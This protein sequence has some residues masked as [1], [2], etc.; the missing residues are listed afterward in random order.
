MKKIMS[1][2]FVTGFIATAITLTGAP[3]ANAWGTSGH[4]IAAGLAESRLTPTAK[5]EVDRLLAGESKPTLSGVSTWADQIRSDGSALGKESGAWHYVNI[6]ENNCS[7]DPAVNGNNGSNIV[8]AL[9]NQT[10]ILADRTQSDASR[11]QALKFVVHLA[12]DIAQPMHG[13]YAQDR[14]GNSTNVT[15][16]G[17]KTNLHSVWDSRLLAAGKKSD[18][19]YVKELTAQPTPAL[20]STDPAAWVK[21]SCN[22]AVS[23][24]VYPANSTIGNE[25][26]AKYLP[27]AE[28]QLKM[29]GERLARLINTALANG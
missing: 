21:E 1:G 5:Q 6:A 2:I 10:A 16:L 27:V 17:S 11:N 13:G 14:G 20:G 3:Q 7:Y 25:Y 22:I 24:G 9:R 19:T 23:P 12:E 26:T 15:Y 28:N 8:E 29:S 18:A 4:N